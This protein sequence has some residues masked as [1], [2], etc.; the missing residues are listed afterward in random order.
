VTATQLYV[1][2]MEEFVVEIF[3]T[4]WPRQ[5]SSEGGG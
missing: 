4:G 1:I 3:R 5:R 2:T